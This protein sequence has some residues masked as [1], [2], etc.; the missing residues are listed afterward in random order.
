MAGR[1]PSGG[2]L[3]LKVVIVSIVA[4]FALVGAQADTMTSSSARVLEA[5]AET[6]FAPPAVWAR[7]DPATCIEPIAG[8]KSA[9]A[10]FTH[11]PQYIEQLNSDVLQIT[12]P[13]CSE[14]AKGETALARRCR[15][16]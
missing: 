10:L 1:G 3:S 2:R 14:I 9:F 15:L 4:L 8:G 13:L 11:A 12:A 16:P 7:T 6:P 5:A